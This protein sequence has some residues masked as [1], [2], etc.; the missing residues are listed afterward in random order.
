MIAGQCEV[1]LSVVIT[2][3]WT[4]CYGVPSLHSD[5]YKSLSNCAKEGMLSEHGGLLTYSVSCQITE[6]FQPEII[7]YFIVIL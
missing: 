2:E 5:T 6:M 1:E 3:R 4:G 7:M